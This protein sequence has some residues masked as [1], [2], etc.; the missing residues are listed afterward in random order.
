MFTSE[1]DAFVTVAKKYLYHNFM[2][3]EEKIWL[4]LISASRI[5]SVR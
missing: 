4:D 5:Q 3:E 2:M 1:N